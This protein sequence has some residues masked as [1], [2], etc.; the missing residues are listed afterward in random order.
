MTVDYDVLLVI[1][2]GL[3]LYREYLV[4]SAASRARTL[5]HELWL[6]NGTKPTWQQQY[7]AGW[8]VMNVF[9]RDRLFETAREIAA[10]HEVVGVLCWDEPMVISS[11][12]IAD[13]LGVPGLSLEGVQGCRDKHRTRRLLTAAGLHQPGFAMSATVQE[14]RETAAKIGYPVVVK[15][16]ALGASIG[17]VLAADEAELDAAFQVAED[18]GFVGDSH[19]HG[20]ALVE[21]FIAGPEISVDGAVHKGEY[22]PMYLA[23]KQTGLHPYFEELGHVVDAADPLLGDSTLIDAIAR[24][25]QTLGV[26]YGITHTE[27]KLTEKGPLIVEINGRVGGDLIPYLGKLVTG[28]DPG[29]VIVDVGTGLRPTL[30]ASRSGVAGIRF[31]YPAQD[32]AVRSIS[33]P[34]PGALQGLVTATAIVEPG[35]ELRLPPGGYIARHSFVVCEADDPETCA[36][37]MTAASDLI[38]LVADPIAAP[39]EGTPF[40]MPAGVLDVDEDADG[41]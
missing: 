1:G 25:H 2:S 5:G 3:Q 41:K 26:E 7:F 22:L 18:A 6:I 11:A 21:E 29:D 8:T 4:S 24:A 38:Q 31:G 20:G 32:C 19:F 16:R 17:V 14:A 27:I 37:R 36:R 9:N 23:R 10:R 33:V 39:P 15:P 40:E 13:E 34:E 28:I 35:T 12:E 30:M